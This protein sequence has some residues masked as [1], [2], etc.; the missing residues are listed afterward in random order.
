MKVFA[1]VIILFLGW[2]SVSAD[3]VFKDNG[4]E[5]VLVAISDVVPE[6]DRILERIKV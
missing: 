3:L 2:G 5:N 1:S 6:D 4:Y